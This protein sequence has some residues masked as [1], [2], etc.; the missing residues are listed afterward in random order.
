MAVGNFQDALEFVLEIEGGFSDHP[1]DPGGKTNMGV[2]EQTLEAAKHEKIVASSVTVENM[3][4]NHAK[5]IYKVMYWEAAGCSELPVGLDLAVFD[6]AVNHGPKRAVKMLQ[7][8]LNLIA[9]WEGLPSW[10]VSKLAVDGIWGSNTAKV[11]TVLR[12][13]LSQDSELIREMMLRRFLSWDALNKA[14]FEKGWFR[15]GVKVTQAATALAH[16]THYPHN[17]P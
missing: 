3:T 10:R 2:T 16:Q 5:A 8:A 7:R 17:A 13:D 14:V 4:E 15:R 6:A 1:E 12:G 11:V 9:K